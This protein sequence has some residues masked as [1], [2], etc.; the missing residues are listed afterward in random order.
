[1]NIRT[2]GVQAVLTIGEMQAK[3]KREL[4]LT[5]VGESTMPPSPKK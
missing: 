2:R 1:M 4:S 3:G 5:Q